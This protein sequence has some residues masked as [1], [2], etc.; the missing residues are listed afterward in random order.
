MFL[1]T[2]LLLVIACLCFV[3]PG[4]TSTVTKKKNIKMPSLFL[5]LDCPR[6]TKNAESFL[7]MWSLLS[8]S[9]RH[10]LTGRK[11]QQYH[12]VSGVE[13]IQNHRF[14]VEFGSWKSWRSKGKST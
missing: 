6:R 10:F 9:I 3:S 12:F 13:C 1:K 14:Q 7:Y 5:L 4:L 2:C 8:T 11:Q